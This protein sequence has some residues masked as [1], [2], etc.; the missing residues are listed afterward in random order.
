M[1]ER[2]KTWW[3][4]RSSKPLN[5]LLAVEFDEAEV[6]VKVIEKLEPKWNQSFRWSDITRVCFKDGGMLSSD[7]IYVSLS[8]RERVAVVP[9]E[10]RGGSEFFGALCDREYFPEKVW[11]RAVGDTSGGLHCWPPAER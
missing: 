8:D 5:Q 11:R 3:K 2:F 1:F 6:H 9:T 7:I 4:S 10:A